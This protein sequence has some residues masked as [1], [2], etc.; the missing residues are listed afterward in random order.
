M[1][2]IHNVGATSSERGVRK[3]LFD[4]LI[5][6]LFLA[7]DEVVMNEVC[8]WIDPGN[9]D[10]EILLKRIPFSRK[11]FACFVIRQDPR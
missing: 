11:L 5:F 10:I 3:H 8:R 7:L 6:F 4:I 9:L 1:K 2:S